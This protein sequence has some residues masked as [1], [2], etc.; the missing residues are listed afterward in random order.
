M[1]LSQQ[2]ASNIEYMVEEIKSKLKVAT[3]A[4]I[5][6]EHFSVERYDDIRDIYELI[7]AKRQ[8]SISEIQA[9]CDELKNLKD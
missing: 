4:S 7:A 3:A 1:D 8:F 5:K 2:T 9:L 6:A